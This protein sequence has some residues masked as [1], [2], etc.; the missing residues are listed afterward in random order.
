MRIV[1]LSFELGSEARDYQ[2]ESLL[3]FKYKGEASN[4][5]AFNFFKRGSAALV[6]F[7]QTTPAYHYN[8]SPI[9]SE[10]TYVHTSKAKRQGMLCTVLSVIGR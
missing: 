7:T 2:H 10:I 4:N 3:R 1:L 6:K 5:S 8:S 9:G